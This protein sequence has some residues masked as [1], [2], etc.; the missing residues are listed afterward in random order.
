MRKGAVRTWDLLV[1][2]PDERERQDDLANILALGGS[3]K[4]P[5]AQDLF[6]AEK[7]LLQDRRAVLFLDDDVDVAFEDLDRLF[8]TF[9]S[10]DLWLAQPSWAHGSRMGSRIA[11]NCPLFELHYTN[12]VEPAAAMFSQQALAACVDSFDQPAPGEDLG[13]A[14]AKLLGD[15]SDRIAV[16]DTVAVRKPPQLEDAAGAVDRGGGNAGTRLYGFV[17]R[18][19]DRVQK[20]ML[21][22]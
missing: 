21:T 10:H 17:I 15:P 8:V 16:I 13:F 7:S 9:T 12:S 2:Y 11:L 4:Y 18:S 20:V 1:N 19:G 22:S 3:A 5:A 14:W 6:Y